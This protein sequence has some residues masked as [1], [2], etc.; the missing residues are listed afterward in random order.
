MDN[1]IL[2]SNK[3]YFQDD[4]IR[5]WIEVFINDRKMQNMSKRTL[6]FYECKLKNFIDFC[7]TK[8]VKNIYQITPSLL[9]EYLLEYENKAIIP[10]DAMPLIEQ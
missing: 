1:I 4:Y 6:E 7:E 3:N 8:A 5:V 9:R 2:I 10:G